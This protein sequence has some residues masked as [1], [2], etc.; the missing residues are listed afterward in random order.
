MSTFGA[1]GAMSRGRS[2]RELFGAW[3]VISVL[4][5]LLA[6][7]VVSMAWR[8]EEPYSPIFNV[9]SDLGAVHCGP[10]RGRSVCSPLNWVMNGSFVLQGLALILGGMLLSSMML[11]VA[12]RVQRAEPPQLRLA[13]WAK[14]LLICSGVGVGLVGIFPEDT[15]PGLHY[16]G[17]ALFF[18]AGSVAQFLLW[19]IWRGRSRT[20]W[21]LLVCGVISALA[22][23]IF[24]VFD[25]WLKT[26]GFAG[27]FF[28]R[29]IVYPVVLGLSIVGFTVAR[30]IRA[31]RK[32][33]RG[34]DQ[35]EIN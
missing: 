33:Q 7:L 29:L 13:N 31:Q 8:A 11:G 18:V 2:I 30:G 19:Q 16:L 22:T 28:E 35:V 24:T 25:L 5:I 3:S 15:I 4:Q 26:P 20:A 12:A 17:A 9:I 10:Y 1:P 21:L 27:G 32:I 34:R 14:A 23:V 6:E